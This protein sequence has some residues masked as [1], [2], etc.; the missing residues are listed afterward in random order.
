MSGGADVI[1]I[2]LVD[3]A[4]V[5][6]LVLGDASQPLVVDSDGDGVCDKI[7]PL[8]VPTTTP[9][10]SND[11]LLVNMVPIAPAGTPT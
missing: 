1:P 11:A 10:S 8:L 4:R 7:N 3:P 2:S 6:L 9:M 5:E